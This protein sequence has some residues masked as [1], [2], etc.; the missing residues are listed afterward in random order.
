MISPFELRRKAG[1]GWTEK[2]MH[3][4][5]TAASLV[6]GAAGKL[7][8]TTQYVGVQNDG[9]VFELARERAGSGRT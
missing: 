9:T 4:S 3:N 6:F 1:G 8:G 2:V 7:Y 5:G